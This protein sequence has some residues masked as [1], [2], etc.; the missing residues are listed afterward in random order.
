MDSI[1]DSDLLSDLSRAFEAREGLLD[2][3]HEGALRLFN[4][5][6]EGPPGLSLVADLYGR[7]LLLQEDA[8]TR[9]EAAMAQTFYLERLPWLEAVV[10]KTRSGADPQARRGLLTFGEAPDRKVCENGVWYALDLQMNSAASLFLDTRG[11]RA[12]LKAHLGGRSA[13]NTFAYTGSLGVAARAGGAAR[14]VHL[15]LNRSFL[16]IAKASYALNGFKIQPSDFIAGDFWSEVN[17]F[18]RRGEL[19]DCVLLDPPFFSTTRRGRVDLVHQSQRVI[20]KVRPLAAHGGILVAINNALFASGA[21]Y[22]ALLEDLCADG[23]L[24]I[25]ELIP[26]PEDFT[27]FPH[28][29]VRNPPTDP[30]PFN[31]STKIAVLSVRR[32]S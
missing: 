22:L 4:G 32:K 6:L 5:F 16:E 24:K 30:A 12:W 8:S 17:A 7:T 23:F 21:E 19:F 31:H 10:V 13:L 14:V 15:D 28:T 18:K 11:L 1:P 25:E 26:V 2:P 3:D 9:R 20:N 29:R 27:G